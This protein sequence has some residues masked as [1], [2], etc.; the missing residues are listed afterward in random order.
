[1]KDIIHPSYYPQAKISCACGNI[2]TI[3]STLQTISVELCNKCH[4]FYTGTQK[5]VDTAGRV[6][7]FK[8]RSQKKAAIATVRKG[9]KVKRARAQSR[10]AEL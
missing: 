10:K 7:R 6:E 4:P 8:Q 1:M 3:G 2:A 9:R 5:L